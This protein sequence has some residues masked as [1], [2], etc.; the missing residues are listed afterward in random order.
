MKGVINMDNKTNK[1]NNK[2]K[3]RGKGGKP[4]FKPLREQPRK[5]SDDPRINLDNARESKVAKDIERDSKKSNA[6]DISEFNKNPEL[7]KS[8]ASLPFA[9]ITGLPLQVTNGVKSVSGIM[10]M[11]YEPGLMG[12]DTQSAMNKAFQQIYSFVV[13]ANSRNYKYEYTDLAMYTLAG[14]E[15]FTAIS[16]AIRVYGTAKAYTEEN[17]Y[18]GDAVIAALGFLPVISGI[19]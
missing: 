19:I 15:L 3:S 18:Y 13:H 16:E 7:L 5:D 1:H 14:I 9:S 11:P 2:N 17:L 8:A 6:N 4:G 12:Y 10:V